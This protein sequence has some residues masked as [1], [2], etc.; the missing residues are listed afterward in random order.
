[1]S[2]IVPS[3]QNWDLARQQQI[4]IDVLHLGLF[5]VAALENGSEYR[6]II[7]AGEISQQLFVLRNDKVLISFGSQVQ[8]KRIMAD[9][10]L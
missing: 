8:I 5:I 10:G 6:L 9:G 1:M 4:N 3:P 2:D 7:I